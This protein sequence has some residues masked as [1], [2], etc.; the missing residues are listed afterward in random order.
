MKIDYICCLL[1]LFS[2]SSCSSNKKSDKNEKVKECSYSYTELQGTNLLND[3][4]LW[5]MKV[6][7]VIQ[8][9]LIIQEL[10]NNQLYGV[11]HIMDDR[12]V[13]EGSFLTKGGGPYEVIHPDLWGNENDSIFYI[14]NFLGTIENIY[15]VGIHDIYNKESW[16]ITKF[17]DSKGNLF[18]PSIV[19]LSDSICIVT[20]SQLNSS[21][22]LSCVNLKSGEISGMDFEFPGFSLASDFKV[23]EH[24]VYCDAQ[25]LKH[26][27]QSKLLY[28]C[29]LGRYVEIL[30]LENTKVKKRIPIFS[31]LP[32]YERGNNNQR[33][34]KDDCLRGVIARVTN[35]RIYCLIIP[36]T[37]KESNEN[38][39]Y[40][41]MPNYYGDE[42]IVFDWNGKL[43]NAYKLDQPIC[44]FGVDGNKDIIYGTTLDNEDFVV[45]KFKLIC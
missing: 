19:M 21:D 33:Q 38:P 26:P 35:D 20:G 11:Y 37:R 17:P 42:L 18:Y 8:D 5:G 7:L 14:S 31:V 39:L 30:E 10:A 45:R 34:I 44:N 6:D 24:M 3:S 16:K 27:S 41:K 40:K 29:R 23:A 4:V 25:L 15:T 28:A 32:L 2:M 43:I 9:R 12:L 1:L 13:K 22:M 36:Y